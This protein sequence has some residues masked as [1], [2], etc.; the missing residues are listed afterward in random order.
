MARIDFVTGNAQAYLPDV[1][2]LAGIPDRTEA[3][4][5]GYASADLRAEPA[6]GEWS[7]ARILRHMT[8]YALETS[9]NL[10][11][12]AWQE[13][14]TITMWDEDA[15]AAERGWDGMDGSRLLDA[16]TEALA[17][18][19]EVLKDL[20]DAWWGRPG[21]HPRAGMFCIRQFVRRQTGH[22]DRHLE[23]IAETLA[24]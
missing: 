21:V 4:L 13:S 6:D 5:S 14:P 16:F 3:R 9:H 17:E 23:Q 1:E 12:M 20:P 18:G 24:S 22:L 19:V 11:R 10:R 15:V 7:A 2:A 8:F